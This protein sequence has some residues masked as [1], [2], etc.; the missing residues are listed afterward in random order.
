MTNAAISNSAVL[1]SVK[2]EKAASPVHVGT[3]NPVWVPGPSV[4]FLLFCGEMK[5]T[6][7]A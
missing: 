7:G 6:A 4:L 2:K 1:L 5:V 3:L